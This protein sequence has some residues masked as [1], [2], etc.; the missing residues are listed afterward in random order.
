LGGLQ[1]HNVHTKFR[2]NRSISSKLERRKKHRQHHNHTSVPSG[3][4]VGQK[5]K[6]R[7]SRCYMTVYRNAVTIYRHLVR[8]GKETQVYRGLEP[9]NLCNSLFRPTAK[10]A[11]IFTPKMEAEGS[12]E[13]SISYHITTQK[14]TS[15]WRNHDPPKRFYPTKPNGITT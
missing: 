1:R 5:C 14:T 15:K 10:I 6:T 12:S 4:E 13:T 9:T 3:R 7:Q 8:N 2:E 11:T